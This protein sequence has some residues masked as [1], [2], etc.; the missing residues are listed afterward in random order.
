MRFEK[1][2]LKDKVNKPLQE[3][4]YYKYRGFE[5]GYGDI[6]LLNCKNRVNNDQ[7]FVDFRKAFFSG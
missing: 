6:A 2:A 5:G 7:S 4:I 3:K 1:G